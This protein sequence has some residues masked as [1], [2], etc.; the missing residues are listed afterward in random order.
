MRDIEGVQMEV[1]KTCK[2]EDNSDGGKANSR[3]KDF[4]VIES[5]AL[6]IPLGHQSSLIAIDGAICVALH[7]KYPL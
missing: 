1:L 2:R 4:E 3:S 7:L 5:R 6:V